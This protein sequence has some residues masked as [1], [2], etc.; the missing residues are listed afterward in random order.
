[1][2]RK[3]PALIARRLE[4]DQGLDRLKM[5]QIAAVMA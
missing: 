2:Q 5:A 1:M 4:I 3:L